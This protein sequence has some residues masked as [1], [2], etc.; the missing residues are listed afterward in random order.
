M[1]RAL[2]ALVAM[3]AP[4]GARADPIVYGVSRQAGDFSIVGTITTDG[5]IG[6]WTDGPGSESE[7]AADPRARCAA[8]S[9][10]RRAAGSTTHAGRLHLL[11]PSPLRQ[12]PGHLHRRLGSPRA[13]DVQL[14][15]PRSGRLGLVDAEARPRA[16]RGVSL[17]TDDRRP[18]AGEW[19][20]RC[21]LRARLCPASPSI[22]ITDREVGTAIDVHPRSDAWLL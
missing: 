8:S 20:S 7:R 15:A 12:P 9:R 19:P 16:P 22:P 11:Q 5:R 6:A 10:R 18:R 14:A 3:V 4:L 21:A 17:K 13:R 1:L 2:V